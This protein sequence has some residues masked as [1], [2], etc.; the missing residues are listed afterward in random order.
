MPITSQTTE[1]THE[2]LR[3]INQHLSTDRLVIS[4]RRL[5]YSAI[6]YAVKNFNIPDELSKRTM[7]IL[8]VASGTKGGRLR[9]CGFAHTFEAILRH[10]PSMPDWLMHCS[11][12]VAL[13]NYRYR[14]LCNVANAWH[15]FALDVST[16]VSVT[17]ADGRIL[18]VLLCVVLI[19]TRPRLRTT[20]ST[21]NRIPTSPA[22]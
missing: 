6:F 12:L 9:V 3:G 21:T 10:Q 4:R 11:V 19:R 13:S 7:L 2:H 18:I 22:I 5:C 17:C 14:T 1:H 16:G 20:L 15:I 8:P